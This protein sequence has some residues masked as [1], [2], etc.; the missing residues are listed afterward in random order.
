MFLVVKKSSTNSNPQ[1]NT[2][3]KSEKNENMQGER[4]NSC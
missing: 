3:L 4:E 1:K 2:T